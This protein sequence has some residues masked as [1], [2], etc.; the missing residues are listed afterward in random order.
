MVTLGTMYEGGEGGLRRDDA[1]ALK[2]YR[3]ATEVGAG[4][5][6]ARLGAMYSTGRGGLQQNEIEAIKRYR[7]GA[8]LFDGQAYEEGKG[9]SKSDGE[10]RQW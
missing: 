1:E 4:R 8:D 9:I 10:A 5:A 2:W 3:R 6:M 7:V